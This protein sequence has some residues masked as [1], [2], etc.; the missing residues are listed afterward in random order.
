[1]AQSTEAV[2]YTDCI[3]EEELDSP[4][5]CPAYGIKQSDESPVILEY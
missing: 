5:N 3:S 1:M 2:E 4:N